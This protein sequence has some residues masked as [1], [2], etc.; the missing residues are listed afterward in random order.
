MVVRG[1]S[2]NSGR[3]DSERLPAVRPLPKRRVDS[4]GEW[5]TRGSQRHE[6]GVGHLWRAVHR[7]RL[8]ALV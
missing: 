8:T 7:T 2:A 1:S 3:P 4:D 6:V 5:G